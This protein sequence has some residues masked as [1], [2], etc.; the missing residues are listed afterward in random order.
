MAYKWK[1]G[2]YKADAEVAGKVFE[3]L[4]KT[5]GLNAKTLVDASRDESAPLHDEFEWDDAIA[6]EKWREQKARVMIC[7][8]TITVEEAK[9]STPVRAYVKIEDNTDNYESIEAVLKSEEKT[10]SLMMMAMKELSWFQTK[11]ASLKELTG[12]FKEI[13]KLK[14]KEER[15]YA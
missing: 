3:E 13:D 11:Y 4:D 5:V 6:G 10:D 14:N 8:L 9:D 1:T 15:K 12:V 2:Y 7:N